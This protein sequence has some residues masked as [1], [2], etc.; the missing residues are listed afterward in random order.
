M[1]LKKI[2]FWSHLIVG[3]CAGLVILS[4]SVTGVLLTYEQQIKKLAITGYDAETIS[5]PRLS[6]DQLAKIAIAKSRGAASSIIFEQD[7]FAPV[8]VSAGRR[9]TFYLNPYSGEVLE[10][11]TTKLSTFFRYL[12]VFHRWFALEGENRSIGRA[13][14]GASNL[15]FLFMIISGFYLWWP[16]SWK[17]SILRNNLLF[18]QNLPSAKAR[19]Y[20]WHHVFG[21]W[22]LIP[23]GLIVVSG[24]VISYPWAGKL[25]YQIYGEE[26]KSRGRPGG[27]NGG[28]GKLY[29][30]ESGVGLQA[31]VDQ[32]A[33]HDSNWNTLTLKLPRKEG[34]A[35]VTIELD[36]GN[37]YQKSAQTLLVFD[38]ENGALTQTRNTETGT[39]GQ[40]ARYYMR[41]VHTGQVYGV[42]GQTIAGLVSLATIF[43]IYTGLALA[44]R[45][46]I[47]PIFSRG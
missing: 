28:N 35:E 45:R 37:G 21:F 44:Y 33:N 36:S 43:M 9:N 1:P 42:F 19:D 8:T 6:A 23:L 4:L 5:S 29:I 32:A 2:I 7:Q 15:G 38:Q 26:P 31:L 10:Q 40:R 25:V 14:T 24:V 17:W 41:F 46:L 39:A 18:R 34:S 16:K 3:V 12:T 47:R 22:A 11:D 20:N 13:I 27:G 30:V